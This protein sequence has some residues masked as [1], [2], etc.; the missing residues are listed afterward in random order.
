MSL[1]I[2][3]HVSFSK[4]EQLLGSVKEAL[5]YKASTF[6]FYT[7]APQNTMRLPLDDNLTNQGL[8]LMNKNNIDINNLVVH[9][10]YIINMANDKNYDFNVA[11]LKEE[12]N[13][14]TKLGVKR[15]VIHPGSHVGLGEDVGLNN[16]IKVLNTVIN[17][18]TYPMICLETM[19]G[20]GSELGTNFEQLKYIMDNIN[21]KDKVFVCLDTCHINDAGYDLNKFDDILN[22]FDNIIGLDK[23]KVVHVKYWFRYYRL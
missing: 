18:D 16:I 23:L 19:A 10:P 2:G 22:E 13:R 21:V 5:S 20:K 12:I 14:V 1:I 6:M 3:S 7:G 9:A 11:F 4:D 8:E 15:L 17:K